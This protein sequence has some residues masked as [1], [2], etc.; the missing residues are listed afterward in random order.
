MHIEGGVGFVDVLSNR[1][2]D[3][4]KRAKSLCEND[5]CENGCVRCIGSYWR[6]NDLDYLKKR[7]I[8]PIFDKMLN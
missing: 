5:C 7:E 4:I 1:F 8:I 2:K 6:Q 3:T